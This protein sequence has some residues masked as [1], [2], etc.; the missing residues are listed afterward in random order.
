LS[1]TRVG[2]KQSSCPWNPI[3]FLQQPA[4]SRI[5]DDR[6]SNY[7]NTPWASYPHCTI[8]ESAEGQENKLCIYSSP[9]FN[10]AR[11]LSLI[12]T[13][14]V[15]A[16]LVK[17]LENPTSADRSRRYLSTQDDSET[18]DEIPYVVKQ[19]PGKGI[20]VIATR[21]IRKFE[22]I[23]TGFP[24]MIVD[25]QLF[26]SLEKRRPYPESQRL[27]Q[28][29]LLQ[30]TDQHRFLSLARG[31]PRGLHVVDDIIRTNAFG[32]TINGRRH[33]ALYPEI[34]VCITSI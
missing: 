29:A 22:L 16:S 13:P 10:Q 27:F 11:G 2:A 31:K 9:S 30:L 4:L 3:A 28:R 17:A 34:A 15:A 32:M 12:T 25:D 24:A 6:T 18:H 26:P 5:I 21:D 33:K 23:M 19:V 8:L 20:G 14:E 7:N 1:L